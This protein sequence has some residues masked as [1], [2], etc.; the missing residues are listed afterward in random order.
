MRWRKLGLVYAPE[1]YETWARTH[2]M[3]PTPVLMPD[4]GLRV[5]FASCDAQMVGRPA[6]VD[7]DPLDPTR[8]LRV[9]R[10]PVLDVGR[11]GCFDDNGVVPS[12]AVWRG[13]EL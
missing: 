2:A 7:L 13:N 8:V 6:Y 3:V 9:A 5:Y 12:C 1:G 11:A 4:G 10:R